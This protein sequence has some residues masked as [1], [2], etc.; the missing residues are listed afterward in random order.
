MKF[1]SARLAALILAA[2]GLLAVP[3]A[4]EQMAVCAPDLSSCEI[5]ENV[6]LTLPFV[7]IAG[8]VVLFEPD[9]LTVSDVFRIFN[10][11][12]DTGSGTGLGDIAFLYSA[13]EGPLPDPSTYSDNVEGIIETGTVTPFVGNGTTYYLGA[14][15][16]RTLVMLC[17][18][19]ILL[20]GVARKRAS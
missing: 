12:V 7:G 6:L 2:L 9:F 1:P 13:D 10:D 5:P 14:P 4:A 16:P 19:M 8:D 20:F 11:V 3:A 18:G 15:E 17:G